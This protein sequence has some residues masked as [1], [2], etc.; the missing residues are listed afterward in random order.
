[1]ITG[2]TKT[3]TYYLAIHDSSSDPGSGHKHLSV[4]I[5]IAMCSSQSEKH[6]HIVLSSLKP[7]NTILSSIYL[8]ILIALV[9]LNYSEG[10]LPIR[11]QAHISKSISHLKNSPIQWP[12]NR[13]LTCLVSDKQQDRKSSNSNV[14]KK[15]QLRGSHLTISCN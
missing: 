12:E 13:I 8:Q 2:R 1:V 9:V 6:R 10:L 5:S 3:I 7:F 14:K 11:L 15:L 4:T